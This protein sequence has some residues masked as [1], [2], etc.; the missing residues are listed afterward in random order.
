MATSS[1]GPKNRKPRVGKNSR[2]PEGPFGTAAEASGGLPGR[3]QILVDVHSC[4]LDA[5][6]DNFPIKRHEVAKD[7][8]PSK[9]PIEADGQGWGICLASFAEYLR[10]LRPIY[11][12]YVHKPVYT[13]ET[14]DSKF[15]DIVLYLTEKTVAQFVGGEK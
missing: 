5:M 4:L 7:T 6:T 15:S 1:R 8:V 10:S 13:K 14:I 11:A 2:R 3:L 12:Y 9:R